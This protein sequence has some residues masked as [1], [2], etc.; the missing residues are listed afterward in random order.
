MS[1]EK[2]QIP[3]TKDTRQKLRNIS[4]K[5]ETYDQ[6]I[7]KLVESRE[8]SQT[9]EG[10]QFG[11][12]N[13]LLELVE[14]NADVSPIE[15][16]LEKVAER[17]EREEKTVSEWLEVLS[18][19]GYIERKKEGD[20]EKLALTQEGLKVLTNIWEKLREIF[21]EGTDRIEL[22]GEVVSGLGEGG[23]YIG[24][25][26]YQTQFKKKIG[27]E[28]YP[29]TLDL[30]LH[31]SS[32]KLKKW[33]KMRDGIEIEGF[34]TEERSFGPAKAF[35]SNIKGKEAAIV[36]PYR[37]HHGE[38][39]LEIISPIELREEFGLEDGDELKIEVEI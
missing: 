22:H 16:S 36:I 26:G 3:V 4:A 33:L 11:K 21:C 18:E 37:T 9:L 23:Y 10:F 2:T 31:P 27:F 1:N 8:V 14:E 15:I 34:S 20:L 35:S 19:Q 17:L 5:G 30:K 13:L 28:A 39:I 29:G 38:D 32:L 25:K 12:V 24:Q 6:I 7:K